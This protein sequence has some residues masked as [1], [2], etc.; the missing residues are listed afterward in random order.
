MWGRCGVGELRGAWAVSMLR[1][2]EGWRRGPSA[3]NWFLG[4]GWCVFARAMSWGDAGACGLGESGIEFG[5]DL[6]VSESQSSSSGVRSA[7]PVRDLT[8]EGIHT[9]AG[10]PADF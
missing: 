7:R 5:R 9:L 1:A 6:P 4:R 10:M 8:C 3:G 2:S